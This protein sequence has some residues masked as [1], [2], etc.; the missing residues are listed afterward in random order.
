MPTWQSGYV[1]AN[2]IRIL[3]IPGSLRRRSY[4]RGLLRA[5][6]EV[7]PDWVEVDIYDLDQIPM[8]SEDVEAE[9]DPEAVGE[10]KRRIRA[11]D[12]VLIATPQY[13]G[14]IPGVLKNALD[15]ASRPH[16]QS[17]LV[18]KPAAVI[19]ATPGG[20]G[21]RRA[22]EA[23]RQ[24]LEHIGAQVLPEDH[25][26]VGSVHERFD[27]EGVLRDELTR[28]QLWELTGRLAGVGLD[29]GIEDFQAQVV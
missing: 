21:A 12:A 22:Q 27:E 29:A 6:Q 16:R 17:G 24:V 10:L 26:A 7:A 11:A 25:L 18:G 13:N 20:H 14:T 4:S 9:G 8:Y 15:W 1:E 5:A 23:T 2:G 28:R 19:S 3:A